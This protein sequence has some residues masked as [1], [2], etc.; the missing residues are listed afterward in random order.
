M[1]IFLN[2]ILVTGTPLHSAAKER[3][4]EAVKFLI[5]NGVFLSEDINDC[6]FNP[7]LHGPPRIGFMRRCLFRHSHIYTAQAKFDEILNSPSIDAAC[8]KIRS[9]GKGKELDS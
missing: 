6:R 2:V 3:K 5:E 7:L 4:K 9:L 1:A 8:G